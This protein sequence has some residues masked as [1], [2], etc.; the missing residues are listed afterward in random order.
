MAGSASCGTG[1]FLVSFLCRRTHHEYGSMKKLLIT[2]A[3]L[4]P[5]CNQGGSPP[6]TETQIVHFPEGTVVDLTHSFNE[7]AVYWPT[8]EGFV[9][10]TDS[11]G[12][13]EGGYY[14][15]AYSFSSAEHGGTHLDAPV[16]FAEGHLSSEQIPVENLMG[17]AVLIDVSERALLDSDY[18]VGIS[19]FEAWEEKHGTIPNGSIVLLRT[20]YGRYWPDRERYMGT[21]ERGAEAVSKLHFPGLDPEAATWLVENRPIHAIGL[22]TP[23]IDRGQ[24]AL[25]ESHRILFSADIPAFENVANLDLLPETGFVIIALP[26][27]IEGGSGGPLRIVAII[28][29]A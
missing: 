11:E 4:L 3:L 12:M 9:K 21:A 25:F 14:Y 8:A 16:H 2:L 24:S 15:S 5:A 19:D 29:E 17:E 18:L 20:G 27:K 7:E 23:S 10:T 28:P 6:G 1:H 26:M 22:D 13:T